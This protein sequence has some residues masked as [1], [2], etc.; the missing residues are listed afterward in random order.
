MD[1][2]EKIPSFF[3]RGPSLLLRLGFFVFLS[4]TLLVLDVRIHALDR[5]RAAMND[6]L[7]PLQS[8]AA[9]PMRAMNASQQFLTRQS[10]LLQKNQDLLGQNMILRAKLIQLESVEA[11][12][13]TLRKMLKLM[14]SD[15]MSYVLAQIYPQRGNPLSERL[16]IEVGEK[17]G[18]KVGLPVLDDSL[19]LLGQV[20]RTQAF[21]SE[22]RL[23]S[24]R[25]FPVPVMVER[26]NLQAVVYGGSIPDTMEIRLLPFSSDIQVGDKLVTSGLD[27]VYPPGIPVARVKRIETSKGSAFSQ[28]VCE[29]FANIQAMG[30]ALVVVRHQGSAVGIDAVDNTPAKQGGR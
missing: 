26:N 8:F 28:I 24:D 4:V 5:I 25:E 29:P 17:A 6:F 7:Y 14:E 16:M 12:N 19:A 30:Y 1:D 18:V 23:I 20:I 9:M 11:E 21:R 27:N 3:N 10:T 2:N 15:K 22:I 13:A